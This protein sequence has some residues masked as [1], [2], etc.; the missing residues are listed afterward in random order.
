MKHY[1]PLDQGKYKERVTG[2][3]KGQSDLKWT[4]SEIYY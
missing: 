4:Y 1:L 3:K 2:E